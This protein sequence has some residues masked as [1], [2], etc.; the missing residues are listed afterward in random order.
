MKAF[1]SKPVQIIG[2]QFDG[3]RESAKKVTD[4]VKVV[5]KDDEYKCAELK[6]N[7]SLWGFMDTP[8]S[9]LSQNT[10]VIVTNKCTYYLNR[11]DWLVQFTETGKFTS[12]TDARLQEIYNEL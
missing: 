7:V 10:L 9:E 2:E 8:I 6:E 1:V 5:I 3:S 11:D 4:W 12:Y